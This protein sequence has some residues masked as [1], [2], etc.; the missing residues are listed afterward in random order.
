[1]WLRLKLKLALFACISLLENNS[2]VEQLPP[3]IAAIPRPATTAAVKVQSTRARQTKA[4]K[5]TN[6][7]PIN[8][9]LAHKLI[10]I[11]Q[12]STSGLAGGPESGRVAGL[13]VSIEFG[14]LSASFCCS[15]GRKSG[16]WV[17]VPKINHIRIN[18]ERYEGIH[19][20]VY[21]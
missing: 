20:V 13:S 8:K 2:F 11:C 18:L 15:Q 12:A 14:L 17:N 5:P 9:I 19:K 10:G 6:R 7:Q 21:L 4:T 1:M 16:W 3:L